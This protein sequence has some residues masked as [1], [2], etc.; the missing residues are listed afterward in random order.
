MD[1]SPSVDIGSKE[2]NEGRQRD[3]LDVATST[4]D[5][6]HSSDDEASNILPR[7]G[8]CFPI[9]L[10]MLI[11]SSVSLESDSYIV[12]VTDGS[13]RHEQ[14]AMISLHDQI[15]RLNQER[16]YQIHVLII[17][18]SQNCNDNTVK[19]CNHS[20]EY[21]SAEDLLGEIGSVSKN[22]I[23]LNASSEDDLVSAFQKVSGILST[24]RTTSEF[25]SFLTME[26]F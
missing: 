26:K 21:K 2:D 22:S 24:N 15:D 10:Q 23:Y 14:H 13:V 5:A 12:W 9:G 17:E 11:D 25:I 16:N 19:T 7:V 3:F 4:S 1:D 20:F 18:L 8:A 6:G